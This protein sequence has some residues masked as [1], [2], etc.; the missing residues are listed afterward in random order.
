MQPV[1]TQ[2]VRPPAPAPEQWSPTPAPRRA[3]GPAAPV[4]TRPTAPVAKTKDDDAEAERF[5]LL[6]GLDPRKLSGISRRTWIICGAVVAVFAITVAIVFGLEQWQRALNAEHQ[7]DATRDRV[8][9]Q[10]Q[11]IEGMAGRVLELN[12]EIEGTASLLDRAQD[13]A[14]VSGKDL[15]ALSA[16]LGELSIARELMRAAVGN[17]TKM[18]EALE[19]K[20]FKE[21]GK[22]AEAASSQ[23]EQAFVHEQ[24]AAQTLN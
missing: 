17:I 22:F 21:A 1:R 23:L 9:T 8:S 13:Q 11:T 3:P 18:T 2:P 7:L 5:A 14:A 6:G 24:R 10:S 19:L 4:R 16:A 15:E 12:A 20:E